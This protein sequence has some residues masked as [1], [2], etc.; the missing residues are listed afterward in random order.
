MTSSSEVLV[1]HVLQGHETHGYRGTF[2]SEHED[3]HRRVSVPDENHGH[4]MRTSSEGIDISHRDSAVDGERSS[5]KPS[6]HS[7]CSLFVVLVSHVL[8]EHDNH[9]HKGTFMSHHEEIPTK[10]LLENEVSHSLQDHEPHSTRDTFSPEHEEGKHRRVSLP[11]KNLGHGTTTSFSHEEEMIVAALVANALREQETYGHKRTFSSEHEDEVEEEVSH[12]SE[13]HGH[14]SHGHSTSSHV[15]ENKME[16]S[17]RSEGHAHETRGHNGHFSSEHEKDRKVEHKDSQMR[18]THMSAGHGHETDG[19]NS[20]FSS[21]NENGRH[22]SHRSEGHVHVTHSH[23]DHFSTEHENDRK[24]EDKDSQMSGTHMSAGHGHETDGHNSHFS[25]E[26][27]NGR[28]DPHR[29][30]GH[31]HKSHGHH[32][33]SSL[34]E[35]DREVSHKSEGHG[36]ETHGHNGH[37]SSEH[38]NDREG[39]VSHKSE[40]H[41]HEI[42][43]HK[44]FSSEQEND[45]H[46]HAHETHGLSHHFSSE[47]ESGRHDEEELGQMRAHHGERDG[48]AHETPGSFGNRHQ[49]GEQEEEEGREK[50]QKGLLKLLMSSQPGARHLF[51]IIYDHFKDCECY[52]HSNRCTYLDFLKIV[53]CVTCKHNTR[54][55]N[56][57]HC[58]LGYFRNASA[59]LDD[60][61]VCIECNCN[62]MGSVH[63]RCNGTGFCQCKD[64]AIGAKCDECLPGYYWKQGCYPNVCDEEMLLCQ[65][66]G[67]CYQNQKCACAP[68]FKGVLCQQP[69]C[70]TGKDCNGATV[71]QPSAATL[72]LC[73]LL[74]RLLATPPPPH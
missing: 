39:T 61:N 15:L 4:G 41:S 49:D 12:K 53:T 68:D 26:N 30:E 37:F 66:G 38:E 7:K 8:E 74:A 27:E 46:G 13:R 54:G 21:E 25:S 65:N 20:H 71:W 11:P 44:H 16:V 63:D 32:I 59:E 35:K 19:H 62:Q 72:L 67:T 69:R 40:G 14:E 10:K 31:G 50:K 28:H 73:T 51:G 34:H 23:N 17:H 3:T 43:G 64:G 1:S 60:D 22:D 5:F 58:R 42:H 52:G 29:S 45:R 9:G 33:F 36:D 18:G 57:Q 24:V 6:P 48:G 56:C 2:S 47:H 70:E 55:Q